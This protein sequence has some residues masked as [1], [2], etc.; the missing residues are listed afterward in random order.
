M[1]YL[2]IYCLNC[3]R[4]DGNSTSKPGLIKV[5]VCVITNQRLHNSLYLSLTQEQDSIIVLLQICKYFFL[6]WRTFGEG[7]HL[8]FP[9]FDKSRVISCY[10]VF[11]WHG[12]KCGLRIA[13]C[14]LRIADCGK[15]T[16]KYHVHN[17]ILTKFQH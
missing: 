7:S 15:N 9:G 8:F 5:D 14:G 10:I 17:F 16:A 6:G 12:R 4:C 1:T 2:I 3:I 11:Q 13:D